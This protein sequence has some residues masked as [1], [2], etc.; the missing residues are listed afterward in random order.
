MVNQGRSSENS[1]DDN[2]RKLITY[3]LSILFKK[4]KVD[5]K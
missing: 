2:M 4:K 5:K 3:H 1:L